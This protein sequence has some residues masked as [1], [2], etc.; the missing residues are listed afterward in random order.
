[1]LTRNSFRKTKD[2]PAL[3]AVPRTAIS[4]ADLAAGTSA[5]STYFKAGAK[6]RDKWR[7]GFELEQL[8][9]DRDNF[10]APFA[11]DRGITAVLDRLSPL[12]DRRITADAHDPTSPLI[13]LERAD[14]TITLEPGAQFE[15]SSRPFKDLREVAA[16]WGNYQEELRA[17]LSIFDYTALDIGYQP[18]TLVADITILPKQRYEMMNRHFATTGKHG[19]NMMRGTA[20]TQVAIDYSSEADAVVKMRVAAALTPLLALLTDNT[21]IFEGAPVRN[22]IKRTAIW[23]DVDAARSMIP[24]G[25]FSPGYGFADYARHV[26]TAPIIVIDVDGISQ[27]TGSKGAIECYDTHNLTLAD[28]DHIL[29]MFF[30]DVRLRNYVEIRCADSV[31]FPYALAYL[32]LLKGIFYNEQN[33]SEL[34]MLVQNFDNS[35]VPKIKAA[36]IADGYDADV[37][38]YYGK[39]IQTMMFDLIERAQKSLHV[40]NPEEAVYL[41]LFKPLVQ[42]KTTLAREA[43]ND[44]L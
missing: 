29:S 11:G 34:G 23:N 21:P 41:E 24:P 3:N 2:S 20:S 14:G 4:A 22:Y 12:Y 35:S 19:M 28:I 10:T 5:L 37:T 17:I 42:E 9:V 43:Q 36:I 8:I 31:P 33:L 15:F 32:A 38:A 44:L 7:I 40:I 1:M 13:G 18:R 25:L 16:V 26:L 30:F 6:P 39:P 27:S